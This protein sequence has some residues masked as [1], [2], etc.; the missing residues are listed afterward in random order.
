MLL[1]INYLELK[2]KSNFVK[3]LAILDNFDIHSRL[4]LN[5]KNEKISTMYDISKIATF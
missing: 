3:K 4:N 5:R 2:Y 1:F